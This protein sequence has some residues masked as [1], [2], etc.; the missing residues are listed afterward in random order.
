MKS[1]MNLGLTIRWRGMSNTVLDI[2]KDLFQNMGIVNLKVMT[3]V[4]HPSSSALDKS[5][6]EIS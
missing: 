5:K 1:L 6:N 4:G 3:E 2:L